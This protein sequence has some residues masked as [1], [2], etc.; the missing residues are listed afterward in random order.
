[1]DDLDFVGQGDPSSA[2]TQQ[3]SA[4]MNRRSPGAR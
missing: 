1:V 4:A 3:A 2:Q